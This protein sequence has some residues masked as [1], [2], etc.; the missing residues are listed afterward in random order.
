MIRSESTFVS[1]SCIPELAWSIRFFPSNLKGFV[2][3]PTVRHPD[4]FA[5][6]ATVGPAPVP[7]PPP[8]PAVIKTMS[9]FSIALA[10]LFRLSSA[11]RFPISGSDPAP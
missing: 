5:I 7:V 6:S 11:A 1:S 3:T 9:A 8:I 10:M 4:S 2:T